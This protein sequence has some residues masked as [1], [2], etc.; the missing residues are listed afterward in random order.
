M[1]GVEVSYGES[2]AVRGVSYDL[3]SGRRLAILGPSGCGKS[4]L[5]R[6]V[7][8]L[9]PV[10]GGQV[11]IGGK[12]QANVATYRRGLGLM[13]QDHALFPHLDVSGNI[14]FGLRMA[15]LSGP[16]IARRV[17]EMLELV[18][19]A[20]HAH[21]Q[22]GDLSGGEQQRVALARTL[23]PRPRVVLLDEP[24]GSL[25]RVMREDLMVTLTDVFDAT[26][27]TVIF[28]THDQSEA[29]ALGH[30]VAVMRAGRFRQVGQPDKLWTRPVDAWVANFLGLNN[31]FSA[32]TRVP[33]SQITLESE[34]LLRPDL[35]QLGEP[36]EPWPSSLIS[37]V[38][39]TVV[40]SAFRGGYSSVKVAVAPSGSPGSQA[41][42][43]G[44]DPPGS[45]VGG[46]A[47][48]SASRR[49]A[50]S[51]L[52]VW[53]MGESP[54]VGERIAV[55]IPESAVVELGSQ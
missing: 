55:S 14:G 13:F 28:V 47:D 23:A 38:S 29:F 40:S 25:D 53:V 30:E 31:M 46:A 19:L 24:L 10:A 7:A 17:S 50:S 43:P 15:K 54:R 51:E 34:F 21:A 12:N 42:A 9:E 16:E 8:G 49:E 22:I 37:V 52:E 27:A 33:G 4:S 44:P 18:G 39:G 32:R 1:V 36:I 45:S 6:A 26:G 5:L 35:L 3:P 20:T 41:G 2:Q 48:R 11:V